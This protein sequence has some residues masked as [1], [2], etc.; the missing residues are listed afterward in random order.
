MVGGE[1][2]V[3][4][5]VGGGWGR[6]GGQPVGRRRGRCGRR[7]GD[8]CRAAAA[9]GR[10]DARWARTC[11]PSRARRA[12]GSPRASPREAAAGASS[13]TAT[14]MCASQRS[15]AS[16]FDVERRVAHPQARVA[17]LLAVGRRAAPVLLEEQREALLRGPEVL[18]GVHRPQHLVVGD[19]AVE[20]VDEAHEGRRARRSRRRSSAAPRRSV[21]GVASVGGGGVVGP[22]W[23][24]SGRRA[25]S[26][27]VAD[28]EAS[29]R[30]AS[31]STP[32][33]R[34]WARRAWAS[35]SAGWRRARAE[36]PRARSA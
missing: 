16:G 27:P 22:S 25:G 29:C 7:W 31:A 23:R 34:A 17:A 9:G 35:S 4:S 12:A 8:R 30:C 3:D 20:R 36:R 24:S 14:R 2:H 1:G 26:S 28:V 11:S 13:S 15:R 10:S 32:G 5:F 33:V 18:L 6:A 19:A 21:D